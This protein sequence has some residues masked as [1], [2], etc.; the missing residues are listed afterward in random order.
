ME[1]QVDREIQILETADDIQQRR[2][3]VLGRYTYFRDATQK[4]RERLEDAR[5]YMYF[6]RDA[7]EL[8]SWILEKL[9]TA[10]DENY[11][12]PINLQVCFII[13]G[14]IFFLMCHYCM[15]LQ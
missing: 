15:P 13:F 5:N 2:E 14:Y 11:K 6:K 4:R 3:Q 8:E 12:D 9:Q 7:D 10:S 1:S